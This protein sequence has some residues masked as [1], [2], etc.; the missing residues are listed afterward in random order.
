M[1]KEDNFIL[2]IGIIIIILVKSNSI[3]NSLVANNT[4]YIE[5]YI[6][7]NESFIVGTCT[8]KEISYEIKSGKRIEWESS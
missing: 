2:H 5:L 4:Y 8:V 6:L 1:W 3:R 7:S